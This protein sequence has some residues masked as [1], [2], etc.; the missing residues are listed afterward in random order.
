VRLSAEVDGGGHE[1][2]MRSGTLNVPGIV[3][4]GAACEILTKEGAAEAERLKRQRDAL[5]E[6]LTSRLDEVCVNGSLERRLP[7]NLNVSFNFV[8]GEALMMAIKDIAVSSGSACTSAS[9]EP[10]Y[11][12]HAMG[13]TDD[14][15]HSSIR[16]GLGRFTSD[17]EIDFVANRVI[18]AVT[19]L[20]DMSPLW[21][22]HNEGIDLNSVEWAAH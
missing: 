1:F 16:F 7:N 22:M 4:F 5:L 9:L 3:G 12:L 14:A 6:K 21:E 15:A 8:E 17:E 19:K 13:V 2:G 11:V 20:R 10:S 18:E